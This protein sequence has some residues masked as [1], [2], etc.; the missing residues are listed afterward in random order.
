MTAL[1]LRSSRTRAWVVLTGL[2]ILA[3]SALTALVIFI[4]SALAGTG[5]ATVG[6]DHPG[7]LPSLTAT[8]TTS[9][10]LV[11]E[12]GPNLAALDAAKDALA[13]KPMLD[14]P[15]DAAHPQP[16]VTST[17]GPVMILPTATDPAASPASGYPRT[18]E[19]AVAQ[20][21]AIDTLAFSNLSPVNARRAYDWAALPGAVPFERWTPQ[22]GVTAILTAAGKPQGALG[23]TSTWTLTHGQVKGVLDD[24]DFVVACV[25]GELDATYRSSV[26]AGVGDCQR[27]A[28]QG[29]R[30]RIAP[31]A[32][33]SF[34][35]STWPG[36]ADC[37]R[38]GWRQV[39]SA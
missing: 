10:A 25:L 13:A 24:G 31:G 20:L 15:L 22:V 17:A 6:D 8:A 28:W 9:G 12:P 36:S 37:A 34:A 26:R 5:P 11:R 39:R 23:L 14:V 32:Q 30:W 2:A 21:G 33:P 4:W 29:G 27:M 38:A 19:G 3:V 18:P 7:P 16:L 1:M 35:P